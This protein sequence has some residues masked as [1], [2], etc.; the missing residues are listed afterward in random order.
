M[1]WYPYLT[2]KEAGKHYNSNRSF[3][4]KCISAVVRLNVTYWIITGQLKNTE[5]HVCMPNAHI[6]HGESPICELLRPVTS[7]TFVTGC[8]RQ[9]DPAGPAADSDTAVIHRGAP[10]LGGLSGPCAGH[11]GATC[12]QLRQH[13]RVLRH[14]PLPLHLQP[15]SHP[16]H[17]ILHQR[18]RRWC[19]K[20][21]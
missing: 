4:K 17:F 8:V 15:V 16:Y 1:I 10:T 18:A 21:V 5:E 12:R 20:C 2:V 13:R 14:P 6:N 9:G 11:P 19:I 3:S 7:V